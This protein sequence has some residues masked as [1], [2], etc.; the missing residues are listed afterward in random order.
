MFQVLHDLYVFFTSLPLSVS[1]F[2]TA[3][4]C[5]LAHAQRP[6]GSLIAPG[7]VGRSSWSV[8]PKARCPRTVIGVCVSHCRFLI[9]RRP[10]FWPVSPR[11]PCRQRP[12]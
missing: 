11:T 3:S 10:R 1:I 8:V 9:L 2:F 4:R 5:K 7:P 12:D 6:I